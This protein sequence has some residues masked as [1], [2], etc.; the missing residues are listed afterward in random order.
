[1]LL[2]TLKRTNVHELGFLKWMLIRTTNLLEELGVIIKI[3]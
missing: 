3:M 1:M 2:K